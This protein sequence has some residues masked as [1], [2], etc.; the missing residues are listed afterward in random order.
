MQLSVREIARATEATM[1][2]AERFTDV[3][4]EAM[5]RYEIDTPRRVAAFMATISIESARLT[6]MEEDLFYRDPAR[7]AD[8]YKRAFRSPSDA[9]PYARNPK[10]LSE[11]LYKGYHGRGL[12]GLT[13]REN[14]QRASNALGID[15]V[16]DPGL[17]CQPWHAAMTA[18]WFWY[19][20]GCN[21]PADDADMSEVTRRVNGPR[22][23]HLAERTELA[24][25]T[26]EWL[27]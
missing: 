24:M 18:A 27:A 5:E 6:K 23:L 14:Y 13:W 26:L 10:G 11:L 22:R 19:E 25:A 8:L 21:R 12:L 20:A 16:G 2:D 9:A 3:L 4:N 1:Q 7:L 15:Y 17:V